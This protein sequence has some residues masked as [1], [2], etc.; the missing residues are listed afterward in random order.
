MEKVSEIQIDTNILIP[1]PPIPCKA[2][3]SMS[4]TIVCAVPQRRLPKKNIP[5]ARSSS[6][7]RP[8]ISLSFAHTGTVTAV[9]R[10]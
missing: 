7:F 6:G 1:P 10:E 8:Q 4:Q 3:A 2:L 5:I 9:A